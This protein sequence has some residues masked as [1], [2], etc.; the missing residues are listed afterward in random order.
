MESQVLVNVIRGETV[1]SIHR[2]HFY[3]VEGE[4]REVAALGDPA[5]VTFFPTASKPFPGDPVHT[6]GA[7][8]RFGFTDDEIAMACSSHSGE[9]IH[10]ER[11]ARMLAKAGFLGV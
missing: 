2:G 6:S 7:A 3:I 9:P 11:V 10:V 1:E 4:G 5:T 8:D